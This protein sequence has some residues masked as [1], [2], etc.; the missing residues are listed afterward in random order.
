MRFAR[1]QCPDPEGRIHICV[2]GVIPTYAPSEPYAPYEPFCNIYYLSATHYSKT[3]NH[4]PMFSKFISLEWKSFMRSASFGKSVA[5]KIFMGLLALYFAVCFLVLGISL[6]PG[7]KKLFPEKEPL[8]LV[9][10][11]LLYWVVIELVFRF[12]MQTLPVM[13]I[14]PLLIVPINKSKVIHFVLLRSLLSFYN[15]LPLLIIVPF[16]IFCI[17]EGAPALPMIVWM[18]SVYAVMLVVNYTNFLLKKKFADRIV[19]LLPFVLVFGAIAALDYFGVVDAGAVFGQFF[20]TLLEQPWLMVV[21]LLVLAV[22][23][24]WNFGFLKQNFYLDNALQ[25]KQK[26]ARTYDLSWT[27]RFGSIAPFL[28]QDLRLIFRNKRP[29]ATVWLSL[30]F[31]AYGLIFY[32]QETYT[33][34]MPAFLVFVGIFVTGIF[35]INFGQFIPSWDSGYFPLMM[36]QNIPMRKYLESKWGLMSVSVIVLFLLSTPYSYFGWNILALNAACALYNLGVNI[37]VILY[38]GSF[39]RKRIDLEKTPFMNYQGTGAAQ[40]LVGIPLLLI[41]IGLWYVFNRFFVDGVATAILAVMGIGGLLLREVL[42]KTITQQY[43]KKK[44]AM[45][46]GFKQQGD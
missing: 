14:K 32:P 6:W 29:K 11:F 42:L 2:T 34:D 38:S 28:Q 21:P 44:Y 24:L 37:P 19:Q 7:L 13:H 17:H 33:Q 27:R 5:L 40:W 20:S 31:L 4:I 10:Q 45:V 25:Q 43:R 12:F 3:T 23:Y 1:S 9:N 18:V 8:D 30:I 26:E 16:G 15:L 35:M 22:L 41:P 39:N 36:A 46:H